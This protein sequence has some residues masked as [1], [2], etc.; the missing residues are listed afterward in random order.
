MMTD[1]PTELWGQ[2]LNAVVS[3]F[4]AAG[5]RRHLAIST[6]SRKARQACALYAS[7][8]LC[9]LARRVG[10]RLRKELHEKRV[11][12][13]K[14]FGEELAQ[15]WLGTRSWAGFG[16]GSGCFDILVASNQDVRVKLKVWV[17]GHAYEATSVSHEHM[18]APRISSAPRSAATG[19]LLCETPGLSQCGTDAERVTFVL[20]ERQRQ[21]RDAAPAR[22]STEKPEVFLASFYRLVLDAAHI[23]FPS[24]RI[25]RTDVPDLKGRNRLQFCFRFDEA[26][27]AQDAGE[28]RLPMT[29]YWLD[30]G[31]TSTHVECERGSAGDLVSGY[32]AGNDYATV[33]WSGDNRQ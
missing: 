11:Y 4:D 13:R 27:G 7:F 17:T 10:G 15:G 33:D 9:E 20:R 18:T 25:P 14:Y 24:A 32:S 29:K 26:L 5:E 21:V 6:V 1:L 12:W 19:S 30:G 16:T 28:I 3:D 2:L 22:P 31:Q 8:L 23:A